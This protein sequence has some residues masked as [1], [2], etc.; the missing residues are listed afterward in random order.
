MDLAYNISNSVNL[1]FPISVICVQVVEDFKKLQ[2]GTLNRVADHHYNPRLVV[3]KLVDHALRDFRF[4]Q[5]LARVIDRNLPRFYC[6]Y[7]LFIP[8][9]PEIKMNDLDLL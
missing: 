3:G 7:L 6:R 8:I 5:V 1:R 4:D 2:F 9:D